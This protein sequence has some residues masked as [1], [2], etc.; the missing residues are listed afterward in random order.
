MPFLKSL[1][2]TPSRD[3][4]DGHSIHTHLEYL[5][6]LTKPAFALLPSSGPCRSRIG[7][8]PSLPE[9]V[10]WPEWEGAPLAFLCQ[11]DLSEVPR[12]HDRTGLPPSGMLFFFYDQQQST[13]GFDPLDRGSW[14]VIYTVSAK[15]DGAVRTAPA[16]LDEDHL[17]Q[18]RPLAFTR[19]A[20]Y[21]D[22]ADERV[23]ALNLS[24]EQFDQ[25]IDLCISVYESDAAHQ[26]LGYPFP[27]QSDAMDL[28][29]QLVSNGLYCGDPSGYS[30]PSAKSLEPGRAD[31]LLLL[32]LDSDDEA[33]MEWGDDGMLYFWI[34]RGDLEEARFENCWM[35]LQSS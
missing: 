33:G 26:L 15:E 34:K 27:I 32:Q 7:G 6:T 18:E 1:L 2:G 30:H 14:Q 12:D 35:I 8:L 19:V 17:Y 11:I 21:P 20:S 3:P 29:C 31:W 9:N 13:W 23:A 25:Y 16:G 10:P 24:D 5:R 22:W 4:L 28:E